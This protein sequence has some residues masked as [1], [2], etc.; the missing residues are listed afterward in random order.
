[1]LYH[2]WHAGRYYTVAA[3]TG[4]PG[5]DG[6]SLFLVER[7]RPSFEKAKM[8][9]MGWLCSDTASLSFTDCAIPATNLL[10][11]E[12]NGFKYIMQNFNSER[13]FLS[14]QSVYFSN[15]LT[16][17][18]IEWAR[19]RRTFGARLVETPSNSPQD[20]RHGHKNSLYKCITKLCCG[21][22]W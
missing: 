6:I 20:C 19:H 14:A 21:S 2:V 9:K 16:R 4:N 11:E 1:M 5:L 15:E 18:T 8:D 7:D 3:R 12:N 13:F 22:I 17:E 10:G